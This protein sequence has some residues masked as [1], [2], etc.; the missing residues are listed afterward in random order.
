MIEKNFNL[1]LAK[2]NFFSKDDYRIVIPAYNEEERI[3]ETIQKVKK[4]CQNVI[5]VDDGSSDE[6]ENVA[7][8]LGVIVLKH[9]VNLGKGAAL[10]TGCDYAFKLG[11][12]K[13]IVL[14]ADGQH[15]PEEIPR[16]QEALNGKEIVFSYRM[17]SKEMPLVLSFGNKFINQ[18]L[19]ILFGIKLKDSQCGYRAFTADAYRKI[20]WQARDYYLETEVV[21]KAGKK[22]LK[23]AEIPIKTIYSDKYKGTTVLDGV[24]IVLKMSLN[25]IC[26]A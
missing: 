4:K 1:E 8:K 7:R 9:K 20:R 18:T 14:D 15:E 5:V 21:I 6:T 19:K 12:K 26:K 13:I 2:K 11:A 25:K 22:K 10:K 3:A 17:K 23:Y 16:F 24:K